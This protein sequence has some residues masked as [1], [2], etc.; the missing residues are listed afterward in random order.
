MRF[1]RIGI[2]LRVAAGL[3][4]I[5]L[6]AAAGGGPGSASSTATPAGTVTVVASWTGQEG[7]DFQQVLAKFTEKTHIAVNYTGTRAL[8]QLLQSDI[9]QGN[10]PDVAILPSPGTLL[11]YEELGRLH[12]LDT[13]LTKQQ[14]V[15]DYG[16]E[17][18]NIMELGTTQIYTLPV[19]T[20]LQNMIWYNTKQ[21]AG[22]SVPGK[23]Q[24]PSWADLTSLEDEITAHGGTPWCLG[25]DSPPVSGWLGTDWIGDILLHQSGI[26]AYQRWV[27]GTLP[28]T[29]NQ[30]ETAWRTWGSLVAGP[31][32]VHGGSMGALVSAWDTAGESMFGS[33][34]SCSL[35]YV[36]SFITVGYGTEFPGHLQ[37]GSDYNFFPSPMTGLPDTTS[38]TGSDAW[39]VSADLL[40]LFNDTPSA[41]SLVQFLAGEEAQ[42]IWPGIPAG[43]ATSADR[44]VPFSVY[45]DPVDAAVAEIMAN[46][47]ATLCFDAPDLMPAT[48][49]NAFYQAVM[50]YLQ[51]PGELMNILQRLDQVRQAAYKAAFTT[52]QPTFT[53]G[54]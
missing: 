7:A 2:V 38:T 37:P 52:A 3:V 54:T 26:S 19:K 5:A 16:S 36:P 21:L 8:D 39:S 44:Q 15:A 42:Q 30:V 11:S 45:P 34:P 40:G 4:L 14:I 41:R 53:C 18:L 1:L 49:Q 10:P 24:P 47:S 9:Q 25:L 17:W 43:G 33:S 23:T 28:W 6:V 31:G 50:E 51:N 13:G 12:P 48:M 35:Q 22:L 27:D 46:P 32:Q 29:S 20:G